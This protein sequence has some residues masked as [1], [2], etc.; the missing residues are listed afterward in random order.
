MITTSVDGHLQFWKK[1]KEG[2]EFVKHFRGHLGQAP[3]MRDAPPRPNRADL[4]HTCTPAHLPSMLLP[5]LPPWVI[6]HTDV[7]T[8]IEASTD[9]LLLA[10][11]G[12]DQYF[13]VYD[14][15]NFGAARARGGTHPWEQSRARRA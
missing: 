10:T 13:K 11:V 6:P 9:G 5:P 3:P 8:C 14:V 4:S 2:I 7:I 12:R 15:I 1:T